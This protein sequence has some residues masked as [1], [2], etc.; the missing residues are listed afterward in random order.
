MTEPA[1]RGLTPEVEEFLRDCRRGFLVTL[2]RDGSPTAHPMTALFADGRLAYNTYRKSVKARN[3]E[4][5]RR[6][7]SVVLSDYED[8][9][10][11]AVVYK[12]RARALEPGEAVAASTHSGAAAGS[13]SGAIS[14]RARARLA[15]GK[16]VLL[17]VE[18]EE[19]D[20][21]GR[22]GP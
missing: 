7:C 9:P 22:T 13:V 1:E 11:R 21:V 19:V 4:R 12:G 18:P 3:V 5:D 15:A 10:E 14:E 16:R 20:F 8:Q 6:T 2:R 17:A